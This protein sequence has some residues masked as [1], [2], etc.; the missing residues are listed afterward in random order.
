MNIE[1]AFDNT[2]WKRLFK[3]M[4]NVSISWRGRLIIFQLYKQQKAQIEI[5]D[6]RKCAFIRNGV[7]QGYSLSPSLFNI[8]I[9]NAIKQIQIK[10]ERSENKWETA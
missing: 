6:V 9:E 7:R 1:K 5:K 10:N 8:F 3:T 2:D 4:R